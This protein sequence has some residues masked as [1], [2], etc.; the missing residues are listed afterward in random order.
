MSNHTLFEI[1]PHW[2]LIMSIEL[3]VAYFFVRL[4]R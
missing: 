2:T 3:S 4:T 1:I